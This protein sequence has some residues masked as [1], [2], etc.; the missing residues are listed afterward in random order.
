M[1]KNFLMYPQVLKMNSRTLTRRSSF[2][3]S[4]SCLFLGS[5]SYISQ[6]SSTELA[7]VMQRSV[8]SQSCSSILIRYIV[9]QYGSRSPY[10][11]HSIPD[12]SVY[13]LHSLCSPRRE[14]CQFSYI[15]YK[16][17]HISGPKQHF[18]EETKTSYLALRYHVLLGNNDGMARAS[19]VNIVHLTSD[20]LSQTIQG[21]VHD[22]G[23]LFSKSIRGR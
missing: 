1:S 12:L 7:L 20:Q 23:G 5:L 22:F 14:S 21:L 16:I 15:M 9:I 19:R 17:L 8:F 4:T 6:P 10:I 2:A 13:L 18:L 11:R 3:K